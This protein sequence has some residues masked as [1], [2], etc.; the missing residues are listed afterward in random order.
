MNYLKLLLVATLLSFT[1]AHAKDV[2]VKH[3][4]AIEMVISCMMAKPFNYIRGRCIM[5][6]FQLLIGG[7]VLK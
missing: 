1:S 2:K 4:F 5:P 6:E 3:T 7:I